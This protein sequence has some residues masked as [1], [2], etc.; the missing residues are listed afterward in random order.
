M[1]EGEV[2]RKILIAMDGSK[3]ATGAFEWFVKNIYK[4]T[5]AVT[6]VYCAEPGA[7]LSQLSQLENPSVIP[8]MIAEHDKETQKVLKTID[9]IAKKHKVEHTVERV[10]HR[11]GR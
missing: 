7:N 4:D 6:M 3:H 5:D 8:T 9:D 2:Q 10:H 1:A 11:R